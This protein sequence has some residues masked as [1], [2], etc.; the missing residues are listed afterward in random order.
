MDL[1]DKAHI[2]EQAGSLKATLRSYAHYCLGLL[3]LQKVKGDSGALFPDFLHRGRERSRSSHAGHMKV[4]FRLAARM[5]AR[6]PGGAG[7]R[8]GAQGVTEGCPWRRSDRLCYLWTIEP[9]SWTRIWQEG[10]RPPETQPQITSQGGLHTIPSLSV[11]SFMA[12]I[13]APYS[14]YSAHTKNCVRRCGC[15]DEGDSRSLPSGSTKIRMTTKDPLAPLC[16]PRY[17]KNYKQSCKY[18]VLC[19]FYLTSWGLV[20]LS[21]SQCTFHIDSTDPKLVGMPHGRIW[22]QH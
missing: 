20:A 7:D 11:I 10:I 6:G 17:S 19:I 15:G 3:Q 22:G 5:A 14:V 2:W 13:H 9:L 8:V 16:V 12:F 4:L 21:L 18:T 1:S